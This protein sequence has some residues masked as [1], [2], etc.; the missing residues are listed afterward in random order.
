LDAANVKAGTIVQVGDEAHPESIA[1][2][3]GTFTASSTVS[4][5]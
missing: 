1:K 3:T 4:A 2:V 5:G